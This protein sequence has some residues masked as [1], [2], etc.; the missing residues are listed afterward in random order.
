MLCR[1][2]TFH[3]L[4]V[5]PP[6]LSASVSVSAFTPVVSGLAVNDAAAAACNAAHCRGVRVVAANLVVAG[7]QREQVTNTSAMLSLEGWF[8]VNAKEPMNIVWKKSL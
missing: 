6:L 4:V 8:V 3:G 7:R 5:V 2:S 1:V